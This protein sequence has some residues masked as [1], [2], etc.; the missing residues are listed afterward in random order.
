MGN[1]HFLPNRDLRLDCVM[2]GK[3]TYRPVAPHEGYV[4]FN[5]HTRVGQGTSNVLL[6]LFVCDVCGH[7]A[8]FTRG[9][10]EEGAAR[11]WKSP[12]S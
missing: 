11:G 1:D 4:T 3:S 2:C 12:G 6:R 10:P 5:L 9:Y 7:H 8:L